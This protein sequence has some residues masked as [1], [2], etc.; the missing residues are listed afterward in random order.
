MKIK[1]SVKGGQIIP[2]V[3]L[4]QLLLLGLLLSLVYDEI[5]GNT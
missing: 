2:G 4:L 3:N 5:Y 1:T